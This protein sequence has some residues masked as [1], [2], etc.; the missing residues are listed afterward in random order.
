MPRQALRKPLLNSTLW[1]PTAEGGCTRASPSGRSALRRCCEAP[2]KS[3]GQASC[4]R[5]A[6]GFVLAARRRAIRAVDQNIVVAGG[7]DQSIDRLAKLVVTSFRR[8]LGATLLAVH[9]H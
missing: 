3:E 5:L 2:C 6:A 8:M 9:S 7:A 1:M 4:V